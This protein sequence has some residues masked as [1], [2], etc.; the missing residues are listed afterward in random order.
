MDALVPE[1]AGEFGPLS[2]YVGYALRR[3]Q[4]KIFG[5]F[6]EALGELDLRPAHFSVLTVVDA[7]PGVLQTTACA[8]LG[9]QKANFVPLLDSLQRRGLLRRVARDGRAN[10]LHL[11]DEGR[12]VLARARRL[13]DRLE[14]RF[15]AGMSAA[16]RKRLIATLNRLAG[17]ATVSAPAARG[18][19]RRSLSGSA[20][21]PR[22]GSGAPR[23]RAASDRA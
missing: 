4:L 16:E 1:T 13:H 7:N 10:G 2:S 19:A 15:A 20:A 12:R 23:S 6:I 14:R 5:D 18:A 9:I 17:I 21:A 22:R 3:A 8:A 11:T